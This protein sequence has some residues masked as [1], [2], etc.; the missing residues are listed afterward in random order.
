M[1]I[2]PKN[3]L[4]VIPKQFRFIYKSMWQ[5]I[6][7]SQTLKIIILLFIVSVHAFLQ[8]EDYVLDQLDATKAEEKCLMLIKKPRSSSKKVFQIM[9]RKF[10]HL[11]WTHWTQK[12]PRH[13]TIG[14][15]RMDNTETPV[16]EM[17]IWIYW[18]QSNP[19]IYFY[20]IV[21]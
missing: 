10:K 12:R 16:L 18:S 5:C 9:K 11:N 3:I 17:K 6:D 21:L 15:P 8:D 1:E 20:N 19:C 2:P 7:Q 4:F 13:M 14:Q